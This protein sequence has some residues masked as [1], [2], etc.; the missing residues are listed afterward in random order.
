MRPCFSTHDLMN[1]HVGYSELMSYGSTGLA[2]FTE[3]T[4]LAH[5]VRIEFGIPSVS[6]IWTAMLACH[7]AA[8]LLFRSCKQVIRIHT[9]R[10]VAGMADAF[11]GNVSMYKEVHESMREEL[12]TN[13]VDKSTIPHV[14]LWS[15]PG[16]AR[17]GATR[18]VNARQKAHSL[19]WSKIGEHCTVLS[20]SVTPS[21]V[22]AAR[23]FSPDNYTTSG[24]TV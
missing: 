10:I 2:R 9:N 17:L 21:A 20:C 16:P 5:L 7:I 8:I 1:R 24:G 15:S 18:S 12:L 23:G 13:A 4:N 22:S 3:A 14:L 19:F 6:T 11:L